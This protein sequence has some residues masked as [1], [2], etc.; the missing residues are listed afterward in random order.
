MV[1]HF[2]EEVARDQRTPPDW[3]YVNNWRDVS[4]PNAIRLPAGQATQFQV[5]IK[6][7]V[8]GAQRELRQT[9]G[10]VG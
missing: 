9:F 10:C 5:D 7:L 8:K 1:E 2:L 3:C 6:S 4:R